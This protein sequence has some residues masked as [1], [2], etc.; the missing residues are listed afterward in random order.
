MYVD[1]KVGVSQQYNIYSK[2]A[3]FFRKSRKNVSWASRRASDLVQFYILIGFSLNLAGSVVIST[4]LI[5][6]IEK[7]GG[8]TT[9]YSVVV[10]TMA[11]SELPAMI[12]TRGLMKKYDGMNLI[13]IAGVSYL[14]RNILMCVAPHIIFVFMGAV[15]QCMT[16][17]VLT[18]LLT[19][20]VTDTC[21]SEDEAMSQT[22]IGVMTTGVGS[23]LGNICGGALLDK[24]GIDA[25]F[26]FAIIV[27]LLGS[28]ILILVGYK[29]KER[30]KPENKEGY[31]YGI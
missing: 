23:T 12:L 17:G 4:Y 8:S 20:Y 14:I 16:Y 7:L 18:P 13:I 5:H 9:I 2:T 31:N 27:T 15:F 30:K 29:H 6:I 11:A 1:V 19:Y 10:F 26:S 3:T 24:A 28:A 21:C 25:M 22:L